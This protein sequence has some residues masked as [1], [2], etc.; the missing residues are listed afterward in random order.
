[1]GETITLSSGDGHEL[2]GYEARP[3]GPPLG[4][5]VL[6]QEIFGVTSHIR[7]V[8]DGY[9]A[10]GYHTVAPALF[11]RVERN[12]ELSYSKADAATGREL[13]SKI[14][15][16]LVFADVA[17][18]R[19]RVAQGRKVA[20]IGYCWGGTV[21]W[22][23]ATQ[24]SGFAASVCYYP[25][26]IMPYIS[27]SPA[28]PVLAHFGERDPIATI[29]HAGALQTAQADRIELHIYKAGHG[30]NCDDS[31]EHEPL[32][33]AHALRRTLNFLREHVG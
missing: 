16:E 3:V 32:S 4:A 7:R 6:L 21:S 17:A 14:P 18:A 8:C 9:A 12:V 26:Q 25:T 15:W 19:E 24:L 33:A 1:M 31:S 27:E 22:R 13:R 28:C 30:F 23:A 29:E 20:S 10:E 11:D 2:G 5:I